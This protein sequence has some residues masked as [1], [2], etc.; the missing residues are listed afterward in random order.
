MLKLILK[1]SEGG[2]AHFPLTCELLIGRGSSCDV[3]LLDPDVSRVHARFFIENDQ[4][5]IEDQGSANGTFL[6]MR[7][8]EQAEPIRSGDL[9]RVGIHTMRIQDVGEESKIDSTV[10]T[11]LEADEPE[12]PSPPPSRVSLSIQATRDA[13]RDEE[14]TEIINTPPAIGNR[15]HDHE[16]T[17]LYE[18]EKRK[19]PSWVVFAGLGIGAVS[20]ILIWYLTR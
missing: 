3:V 6:N 2:E 15:S 12:E 4:C 16:E 14:E 20:L 5:F 8:I 10:L 17:V 7:R 13:D 1:D 9:L 18:T 19:V 11:S